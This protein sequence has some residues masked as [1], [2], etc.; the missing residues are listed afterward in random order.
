MTMIGLTGGIASGKSTVSSYLRTKGIPIFDSDQACHDVV[1]PETPCLNAVVQAF[2]PGILTPDGRMDRR[3]VAALAFSNPEKLDVLN[4]LV[5]SSISELRDQFLAEH[6]KDP[7]A[8]IDAPL[9]LEGGW[10]RYVDEVW[11]VYIPEEEQIRRA[12]ARS[13]MTREEVITRMKHQMPL[14]EKK[15]HAQVVI[16]NSGTLEDLYRQVDQALAR[17][18]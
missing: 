1:E 5:R 13:Q 14:S 8:V 15:K 18:K 10:D 7:V 12:M 16:D 6:G 4:R 2:G 9:L 11:V 17:L 3:Q